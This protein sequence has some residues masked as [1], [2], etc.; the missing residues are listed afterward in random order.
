M[1]NLYVQ[2]VVMFLREKQLRQNVRFATQAQ[3]NSKS[4]QA[5]ENGLQNTLSVLL[6][7]LA[8]TSLQI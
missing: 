6:R 5:K 8:K 4:R 2:Y 1:K 3:I 7:A